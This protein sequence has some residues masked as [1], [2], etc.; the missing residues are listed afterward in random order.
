[1]LSGA[2]KSTGAP[3]TIETRGRVCLGATEN[4]ERWAMK[5]RGQTPSE[6]ARLRLLPEAQNPLTH[7]SP[8]PYP[9]ER[10]QLGARSRFARLDEA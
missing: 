3:V 10:R 2:T 5:S 4:S 8:R 1:M 6:P 9:A 7:A